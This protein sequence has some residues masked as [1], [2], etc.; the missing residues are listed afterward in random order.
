MR[1]L[2]ANLKSR[3]L[4]GAIGL[5]AVLFLARCLVRYGYQ[6]PPMRLA[7]LAPA[8]AVCLL[9]MTLQRL[10]GAALWFG[11]LG[12]CGPGLP[13]WDALRIH[14]RAQ[15]ARYI[16]GN[17]WHIFNLSYWCRQEGIPVGPVVASLLLENVY[18]VL[19]GAFFAL[20]TAPLWLRSGSRYSFV[21]LCL[22][23]PVG[24]LLVHPRVFRPLLAIPARLLRKAP[25][26]CALTFGQSLLFVLLY[27][28]SFLGHGLALCVLVAATHTGPVALFTLA[29]ICAASWTVGFLSFLTPAGLGVREGVMTLML[30][31]FLPMGT[32]LLLPLLL[33]FLMV[34][35]ELVAAC[36]PFPQQERA[37]PRVEGELVKERE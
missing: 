30:A 17:V 5:V 28:V 12:S 23:F 2:L 25:P 31:Q 11:V 16:P 20:V 34:L 9:L 7:D 6:L 1:K 19:G 24:L 4:K 33:R 26:D 32:A 36:L 35:G 27:G 21:L 10:V 37:L 18:S 15:L 13:L 8:L 22:A 3:Q 29:G 14:T